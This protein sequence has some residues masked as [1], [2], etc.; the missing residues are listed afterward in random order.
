[1]IKESNAF[2]KIL[3][4]V[5]RLKKKCEDLCS[6]EPGNHLK[7]F[8]LFIK[9]IQPCDLELQLTRKEESFDGT[10]HLSKMHA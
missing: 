10:Q 4:G 5:D 6:R 7:Q 3:L 9:A 2:S 1:M 8:K